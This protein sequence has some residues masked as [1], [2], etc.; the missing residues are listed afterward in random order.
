MLFVPLTTATMTLSPGTDGQCHQHVQ[1]DAQHRGSIGIASATTFLFRR[2]QLHTHLLA[3]DVNPYNPQTQIFLK[4]TQSAMILHGSDPHTAITQS[5]GALWGIVERQASMLP[6]WI[7]SAPW[8]WFSADAAASVHHEEA[9]TRP[10]RRRHALARGNTAYTPAP[11]ITIANPATWW[12]DGKR[13]NM[14]STTAAPR[15]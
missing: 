14:M 9:E 15:M 1:P 13:N 4:G 3:A 11:A 5:Y 6:S 2:Q 8:P 7:R 12:P 10:R